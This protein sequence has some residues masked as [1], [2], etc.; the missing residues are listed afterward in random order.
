M[1]YSSYQ[2]ICKVVNKKTGIN[3][4]GKKYVERVDENFC[5]TNSRMEWN[6][7][8]DAFE[9]YRVCFEYFI[10]FWHSGFFG[11][12]IIVCREIFA[13]LSCWNGFYGV[14]CKIVEK[15]FVRLI[16]QR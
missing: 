12:F 3:S 1:H 13:N 7:N 5:E 2:I 15:A 4:G 14:T 10:L 6:R 9:I 16:H 11:K 8:E